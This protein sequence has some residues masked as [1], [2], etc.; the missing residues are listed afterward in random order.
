M[1]RGPIDVAGCARLSSAVNEALR[2][3]PERL[4]LDLRG[5]ERIDRAALAVLVIARRR[6]QRLGI[7]LKLLCDVPSALKALS[8]SGLD[9]TFDAYSA[10]GSA[11]DPGE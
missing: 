7:K 9:C 2:D 4:L 5:V 3:G 8:L 1:V 10:S 6:A 11:L